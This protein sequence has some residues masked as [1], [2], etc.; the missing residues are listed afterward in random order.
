M[1]KIKSDLTMRI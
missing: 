1:T